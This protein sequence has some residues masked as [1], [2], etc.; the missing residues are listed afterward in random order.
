MKKMFS[1]VAG[2]AVAA[3]SLFLSVP[4]ANAADAAQVGT[5]AVPIC[6]ASKSSSAPYS[7]YAKCTRMAETKYVVVIPTCVD[8]RGNKWTITGN[9]AYN[10]Q[11]SRA[12]CSD[13]PNVGIAKVT[14]S[15]R[16]I[17]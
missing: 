16:S 13:N 5:T 6:T 7:A 4:T 11:T 9:R 17:F 12:K 8:P 3:G 10:G 15:I 1:L 2:T 14:Y